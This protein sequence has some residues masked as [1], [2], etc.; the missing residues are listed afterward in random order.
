MYQVPLHSST[1]VPSHGLHGKHGTEALVRGCGFGTWYD[2]VEQNDDTV[3]Q[4]AIYA[5]PTEDGEVVQICA[6]SGGD[7]R[8]AGEG[9]TQYHH[10]VELTQHPAADES[11]NAHATVGVNRDAGVVL[12][13]A[14]S[15][16]GSGVVA[17]GASDDHDEEARGYLT[18]A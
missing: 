5:I 2:T 16:N 14:E 15:C 1:A 10:A 6:R 7:P 12:D 18:V 4:E 17:N 8:D 3:K 13:N 9:Q 11:T